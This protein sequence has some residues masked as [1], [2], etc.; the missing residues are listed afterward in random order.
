MPSRESIEKVLARLSR[1][2]EEAEAVAEGARERLARTNLTPLAEI[3]ADEVEGA[4]DD[5]ASAVR[6]I[7]D[8]RETKSEL[9]EILS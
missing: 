9:R 8:L 7:Q 4:A 5:L 1:K 2:E 3:N 6:R